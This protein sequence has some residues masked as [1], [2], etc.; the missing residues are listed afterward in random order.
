MPDLIHGKNVILSAYDTNNYY[1]F[2]CATNCS[3]TVTSEIKQKTT[4]TSGS[5]RENYARISQWSL[6]LSGVS[7]IDGP[8]SVFRTILENIRR[9]GMDIE[10]LFTDDA[11]DEKALTGHVLIEETTINGDVNAWSDYSVSF[12]GNGAF[13]I[14]ASPL[15]NIIGSVKTYDF[16]ASGG[17]YS[18]SHS[19]LIG[20]ADADVLLAFRDGIEQEVIFS[21]GPG[22]RQM[23]YL[24]GS[25][26]FTWEGAAF[27]GE[28]FSILY[29]L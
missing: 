15:T 9:T 17:E 16:T 25:G 8:N 4:I 23:R 2:L 13:E 18:F 1:P 24:S 29:Q 14:N 6:T 20:I 27:A 7:T 22:N 21:G 11:G 12:I 26:Q 10:L 19:S 3:I 28:K 5:W